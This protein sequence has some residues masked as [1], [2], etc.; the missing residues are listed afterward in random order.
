[1]D[2]WKAAFAE[3]WDAVILG[4]GMKECLLSGLLSVAGKKVLHL[5]RNDYYGGASASLDIHQLFKKFEAGTPEEAE[6]G[7]LRDYSVDLVPKFIMAGGQLVKVLIHTGVHNYM[8]FK[9]VDGSFVYSSKASKVCK[10]PATPED[11]MKSS[12][13]GMME[14]T[15]MVQF[16]LWVAKV[17]LS[18]RKTWVAGTMKKTTLALDT[19]TGD[20]FFAYWGLD[21]ATVEFLTHA[22]C[23]Y[24]DD[25]YRT[26]PAIE[27]VKKMQLYLESKTRFPGMTS[28]YVYPLYGLGEL[29]Q[30]FA[31]L[32]AVHGGVYMLNRGND[33]GPVFGEGKFELMCGADGVATGI[34]VQDTVANAKVVVAD[35]SYFPDL[36][37][38]QGTVV[39]AIA[40]VNEPVPATNMN[41]SYQVIF[42]GGTIGRV[43][44]VYLFCCSASH[45][46]AP[47]GKYLVFCSTNVEG[48]VDGT[49]EAIA[50]RELAAGLSLLKG[51][52]R[53]FYDQYDMMVPKADG[54][55]TKC[56]LTESFDPTTHFETAITDVL[57]VYKR[58][59]GEA[60]VLTDGPAQQ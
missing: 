30:S 29:P 10:V 5:D 4:T 39:R 48:A 20:K 51:V 47:D 21:K 49:T 45:K 59:T 25:S 13:M 41:S 32:A 11:A 44:D 60:L 9:P 33:D 1:M 31:R 57:N 19:M 58:I 46:V 54:V 40:I 17:Q 3:E 43:N 50:R 8:E 37:V 18:D 15:R 36:C 12:L 26:R 42:P 35:P 56:F 23:L 16:T 24:R 55:E 52:V 53:I 6:L 14:K 27:L 7:K 22:C 28:P 34:K 38:K 2:D